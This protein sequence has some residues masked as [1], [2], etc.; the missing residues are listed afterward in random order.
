M[1]INFLVALVHGFP[2]PKSG[3]PKS[4]KM[5]RERPT[6]LSAVYLSPEIFSSPVYQ[7]YSGIVANMAVEQ[8]PVLHDL[9]LPLS[10][11]MYT[12]VGGK[13]LTEIGLLETHPSRRGIPTGV[14]ILVP[15]NN[16]RRCG[17]SYRGEEKKSCNEDE[18]ANS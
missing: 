8:A 2:P 16:Y 15:S 12:M 10:V 11:S 17:L 18:D 5:A 4:R 7:W 3:F 14:P 6:R 1:E 13:V 9:K